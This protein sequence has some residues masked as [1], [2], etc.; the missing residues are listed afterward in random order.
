LSQLTIALLG[1]PQIEINHEAVAVDTRK[2]IALLAYLAVSGKTQSRDTLA[3]LLWPDYDQ[4]R[5]RAALRRTLS[6]L[7]KAL[8]EN[9]LE[10]TRENVDISASADFWC[11]VDQFRHGLELLRAHGHPANEVCQACLPIL[12]ESVELYRDHFMAGFTLRDSAEF[13]NWQFYQAELLRREL[14]G[15]LEKLGRGYASQGDFQTALKYALRWSAADPLLEEAHRLLIQLLAWSGQR[16]AALHQYQECVRILDQE[17]GV[18]PLDETTRLYQDVLEN[19][20]PPRPAPK[21]APEMDSSEQSAPSES[22]RCSL[23]MVG[24]DAEWKSLAE[25]YHAF[26]DAGKFVVLVGEMGIGKTCLAEKFLADVRSQGAPVLQ[27]RCYEGEQ[28]LAYGPFISSMSAF[29][30]QPGAAKRLRT[31]SPHVLIE[32]ARL[33][34]ELRDHFPDLPAALPLDR[35]GAQSQFLEGL[36]QAIEKLLAGKPPGV[37]FFD[38]LHWSDEASLELLAYLLHRLQTTRIFILGTWR[39]DIPAASSGLNRLLIDVQRMGLAFRIPLHRL[40]HEDLDKLIAGMLPERQPLPES[41][42]RRFYQETEGIPFIALEYLGLMR[43][44]GELNTNGEWKLPANVRDV[45]LARLAPVDETA[46]QL[47][48]TAAVIGRSFDFETLRIASGRSEIETVNGL[49]ALLAAGLIEEQRV[50]ESPGNPTY[51]FVHEKLRD[52]VYEQTNQARRRLLHRRIG[53]AIH[54]QGHARRSLE[55]PASQIAHHYRLAGD[56][57]QSAEF[58][59]L[60]GDHARSLF[61]NAEALSHYQASLDAGYPEPEALHEAL[62]DLYTLRGEYASAVQNYKEAIDLCQPACPP[63]LEQKL[64][65]IYARQGE[66]ILAEKHFQSALDGFGSRESSTDLAHLYASWSQVAHQRGQDQQAYGLAELALQAA[67]NT[68]DSE[69]LAQAYNISGI[70]ARSTGDLDKA[71]FYLQCSLEAAQKLENPPARVAALNNLALVF[72]ERGDFSEAIRLL[73]PALEL[74]SRL[75]DRH[76]EAALHNNLADLYHAEGNAEEAMR[77]LKQAVR[78]FAEIGVGSENWKPEIW[79]LTEW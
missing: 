1:A 34:P 22:R 57:V 7:N 71:L 38:D 68:Q 66:W 8:G 20:L 42:R 79:K 14:A 12:E 75:G 13:D 11:D 52:I 5:A 21:T 67:E 45:L 17:L 15:A 10:I 24:R 2:A 26:N 16:N 56:D 18:P 41:F 70:L 64:G 39:S 77:H 76:R 51:D 40:N 28:G 49:E 9:R 53:D 72:G 65:E 32:A 30:A 25:A 46:S 29:L 55:A 58:Y 6:V 33:L 4:S 3:A 44:G 37:L 69:A 31:L 73:E 50:K 54:S 43:Q 61:A 59:K 62:G 48:G 63:R 47:V 36:L 23:P 19:R 60:A 35:P 27:A 74:C 78:I